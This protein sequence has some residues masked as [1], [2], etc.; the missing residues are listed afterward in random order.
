MSAQSEPPSASPVDTSE[1][2]FDGH[3][4]SALLIHGLTGTPYEMRYLGERLAA[5]GIRV[6]GVR[7]AGHAAAPEDLGQVTQENW[8]ESVVRG[9]EELRAYGDP[10]IAVGLSCGAVLAAR[11]VEDQANAVAG[12][13]MLAPA[14]FLPTSQTL[15]LKAVSLLGSMTKTIYLHNQRSSDIHDHSAV[16]IH[17]T[18]RLMPLSAPIELLKLSAMVRARLD[19]ITVPTLIMHSIND[20]TCPAKRNVDYLM[21]RLAGARTRLVM[22]EQSYHVITVDSDKDRIAGEVL[23]FAQQFRTP[24]QHEMDSRLISAHS[25]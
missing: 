19:R 10:I 6:R 15:T 13:V 7:L 5:N 18:C 17:P 11:L 20:H 3:G 9:F 8:Y 23:G 25:G 14:F 24:Q 2:F 21:R 1:F 4:L 22:L 12:L 16:L